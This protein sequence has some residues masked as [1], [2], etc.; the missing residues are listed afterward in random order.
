MEKSHTLEVVSNT[1]ATSDG[2][3]D[4]RERRRLPRLNLSREQF[5]LSSNGK[6]FSV[7]DLS[8]EGM[9]LRL[10]D[11]EDLILFSIGAELEGS[12]KLRNEKFPVRARVRHLARDLVGCEFVALSDTVTEVLKKSLDPTFLGKE[13][14]PLPSDGNGTLWYHGTS[15]TD[16]LFW[17]AADEQ[18]HRVALIVLGTFVQWDQADGLTTGSVGA[19]QEQAENYG[20]IRYETLLFLPDD[21]ADST[22][23]GIA[24]QLV[25]SS[26][27]PLDLRK[28]CV[29]QFEGA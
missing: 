26:N 11:R 29:Q 2:P 7:I 15:G 27:L 20:L 8:N 24:K 21:N 4:P 6:I 23:L 10:I 12:L 17:R 22:K 18:Y 1:R 3:V 14:R 25:L 9:A 5:R 16:L 28:W 19:S 13:L